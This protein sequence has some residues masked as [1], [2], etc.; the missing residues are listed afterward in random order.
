MSVYTITFSPTG[1]TDKVMEIL[2]GEF[3]PAEQIDLTVQADFSI[4]TFTPEDICLFGVPSYAGRVPRIATERI[5]QLSGNGAKAVL[6][7]VFGNRAIDDTLIEL[8]DTVEGRGFHVVGA[9]AAVAEHSIMRQ[10]G[11]GRPDALDES[12]LLAFAKQILKKLRISREI[13]VPGNRPYKDGTV[14]PMYPQILGDCT[15]CGTCAEK[16]PVGA[17][18][19]DN[20][21]AINSGKC[22]CC[23]RCIA[24]CPAK[25]R[26]VDPQQLAVKVQL[27]QKALGGRKENEL[28]I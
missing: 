11:A 26:G 27:L 18:P 7:A 10:F 19:A 15:G 28:Y 8:K 21:T 4:H 14:I 12:E 22:I 16:C 20:P 1:G 5:D 17:I 23:M 6:V 13:I 25:A 24:V 3:G 2:A 9:I